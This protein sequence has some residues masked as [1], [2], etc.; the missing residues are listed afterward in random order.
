MK[1]SFFSILFAIASLFALVIPASNINAY[2]DTTYTVNYYG[3]DDALID[4]QSVAENGF[5]V[6]P[7]EVAPSGYKTLWYTSTERT[8]LYDF[9]S[10]VAGDVNL[11]A[12]YVEA[13]S[14]IFTKRSASYTTGAT[15][16]EYET[17]VDSRY[18]PGSYATAVDAE[19]LTGYTFSHWSSSPNG[20]AFDFYNTQI[21][22]NIAL[23]PVYN[24]SKFSV[25]FYSDGNL[26]ET[27]EVEY[28][29]TTTPPTVS[30]ANHAF[31]GWRKV[32]AGNAVVDF[33]IQNITTNCAYEA[34]FVAI[35]VNY[36]INNSSPYYELISSNT[37]TIN[38][39]NTIAISLRLESGYS[40]H[41][42]VE[43]DLQIVGTY[44]RAVIEYIAD[45][46]MYSIYLFNVTT[47]ITFDIKA[48]PLNEYKVTLPE[49]EG[50]SYVITTLSTDYTLSDGVYTLKTNKTFSFRV[51]VQEGYFAKNIAF[52]QCTNN[53]GT[54]TLNVKA[55]INIVSNCEVVRCFALSFDNDENVDIVVEST[56]LEL[57]GDVY[58]YE[59]G[60]TAT[61]AVTAKTGYYLKGVSG[62]NLNASQYTVAMTEDKAVVINAVQACTMTLTIP[63]GLENVVVAP[64]LQR[65][66]SVYTIE[67]GSDVNIAYTISTGYT[68]STVNLTAGAFSI[69]RNAN[70]FTIYGI[71][72]DVAVSFSGVEKNTY[73]ITPI[74]NTMVTFG[75]AANVLFGEDISISY[76]L[77]DAYNQDTLEMSNLNIT[78]SYLSAVIDGGNI[79]IY[80]VASNIDIIAVDLDINRY[81]FAMTAN[82]FGGFTIVNGTFAHGD[83]ISAVAYFETMYN[84]TVL[85]TANIASNIEFVGTCNY[86]EI[87]D[88]ELIIHGAKSDITISLKDLNKNTYLVKLPTVV[89]G[90]FSLSSFSTNIIHG[91]NFEFTLTVNASCSQSLPAYTMYKNGFEYNGTQNGFAFTYSLT[92]ITEDI[93]MTVS[94][95]RKNT[96]KVDYIDTTKDY[97]NPEEIPTIKVSV[98]EH[99]DLVENIDGTKDGYDFEGWY[100][101]DSY[102]YAFDFDEPITA[103][104]MIYGKYTIRRYEITFVVDGINIDVVD[105][106]HGTRFENILVEIPEKVG[107]TQVAPYWD[108]EAAGFATYI[109]GPGVV[110]AVYTQNVYQ[111]VFKS[112]F[113]QNPLKTEEVLH[114]ES[115][116]AP[117]NIDVVGYTFSMWDNAFNVVMSDIVINAVYD[118]NSYTITFINNNTGVVV[119]EQ[120]ADYNTTIARPAD[121]SVA[122]E[123][124]KVYGW[125]IDPTMD[126][127]YNFNSSVKNDFTLYGDI[128][129]I[130]LKLR[131]MADGALVREVSV[132]YD[133]NYEETFPEIPAKTGYNTV[134]WSQSTAIG[135]TTD[136]VIT[137][138]Y[139]IKTY[140]VTFVYEDGTKEELVVTH[141]TTINELPSKGQGFGKKIKVDK[142]LITNISSDRTINVKIADYSMVIYISCGVVAL[143]LIIVAIILSVRVKRNAGDLKESRKEPKAQTADDEE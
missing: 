52:A 138:Q 4:T 79:I 85:T 6:I 111:V 51:S 116:T 44:E 71:N 65:S 38:S 14:V 50:V 10:A 31:V 27:K 121:S 42:L 114:G 119:Y 23:Y 103:D 81:T 73:T 139:E 59:Q 130:Y 83:D 91:G 3:T 19:V 88:N 109:D 26:V 113:K 32:G 28:N 131:F 61:F 66:G 125:Y 80:G 104:T 53:L 108:Y 67:S 63:T 75:A 35:S 143:G 18:V 101:D 140:T 123:G 126:V 78:G 13:V 92:N 30:K 107:Y 137:A 68:D 41:I 15:A 22:T 5:A 122:G 45:L 60:T 47:D 76:Q 141:G 64:Y 112:P 55:D 105:I 134:G 102:A 54:Y 12:K 21:T 36:T 117:T 57:S 2:A 98:V 96:Y 70:S 11:Y 127:E 34:M 29:T 37:G 118:I 72:A 56:Y 95:L 87:I 97:S 24:V 25:D 17:H 40:N 93:V 82:E 132:A 77:C 39:G 142:K 94:G 16:G 62:A 9:N 20:N 46:D 8:A 133:S 120:V 86:K 90:Q 33:A 89:S 49:V 135:I 124:Y 106:D 69:S 58:K 136:L 99:G 1:K 115:A 74:S 100:T 128:D 84:K 43:S 48:L 110:N 7:A 129:I